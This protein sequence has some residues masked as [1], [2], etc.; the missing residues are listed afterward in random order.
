V[1]LGLVDLRTEVDQGTVVGKRSPG[2]GVDGTYATS[3]PGDPSRDLVKFII[4]LP[5]I[6][7]GDLLALLGLLVGSSGL[8]RP[9]R[10]STPGDPFEDLVKIYKKPELPVTFYSR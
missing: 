2:G 6:S 7:P 10:K 8:G 5:V 3:A 9:L 1:E 4:Q